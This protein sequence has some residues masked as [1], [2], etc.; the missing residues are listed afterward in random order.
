MN[1]HIWI[2]QP[3]CQILSPTDTFLPSPLDWNIFVHFVLPYSCWIYREN[4]SAV[5]VISNSPYLSSFYLIVESVFQCEKQWKEWIFWRIYKNGI[6]MFLKTVRSIYAER[7]RQDLEDGSWYV[8]KLWL[9]LIEQ[10]LYKLITPKTFL[11]FFYLTRLHLLYNVISIYFVSLKFPSLCSVLMSIFQSLLLF[12]VVPT[13]RC[14]GLVYKFPS[15][16][17]PVLSFAFRLKK[18]SRLRF[19]F[20][21]ICPLYF[22]IVSNTTLQNLPRISSP[23]LMAVFLILFKMLHF[24]R[25]FRN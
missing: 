2:F 24:T 23:F 13:G 22:S 12:I 25:F 19:I 8:V 5:P 16:S 1:H 20:Y 15:P 14:S 10:P 17:F 18:S 3:I 11:H 21:H 9:N 4:Q 7:V 6:I